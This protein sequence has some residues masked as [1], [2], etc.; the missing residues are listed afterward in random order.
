MISG[1]FDGLILYTFIE[2]V[3]VLCFGGNK[4]KK[5]LSVFRGQLSSRGEKQIL[6][7]S[8]LYLSKP[9]KVDKTLPEDGLGE[10]TY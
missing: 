5:A 1:T 8:H 2:Q 9:S 6:M 4:K 7:T 3:F 10:R